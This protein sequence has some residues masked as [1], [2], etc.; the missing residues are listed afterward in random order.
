MK[1]TKH[2]HSEGTILFLTNNKNTYD[3][4]LWL[5]NR[6]EKVVL[7][8]DKLDL[9]IVRKI[10]PV[11][12]ISYNYSFIIRQE[13]IDYMNRRI[14]NLHISYLPWN[15][16]SNPN[17]WS[18]IENTPKGV[19]IH[20]IDS[21]LDTGDILL[22]EKVDFVEEQETFQSSYEKLTMTMMNLFMEHW[23]DIKNNRIIPRKQL[24]TGSSHNM[25][26]F[27][28]LT[29]MYP[30]EWQFNIAEY[31]SKIRNAIT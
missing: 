4:Y 3:L 20:L 24:G 10:A 19:T 26:N 21:G 11:L 14:I 8:E 7:F 17:Y 31:K 2:Y 1:E 27:R 12:I 29:E 6:G 5:Q 13:V 18:F 15:R 9:D 28:E 23:E 25:K 22:Q 30:V 16:G